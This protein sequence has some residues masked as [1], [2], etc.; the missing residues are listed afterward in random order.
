MQGQ[1]SFEFDATPVR[2][3]AWC[4]GSLAHRGRGALYCASR[5]KMALYRANEP[6]KHRDQNRRYVTANA[7]KVRLYKATYNKSH[8]R[9]S[10][11]DAHRAT[12]RILARAD[13]LARPDAFRAAS[14]KWRRANP[15]V[16]SAMSSR[17]RARKAGN[18][19]V[20]YKRQ[21]IFERD[22]WICQ[23]CMLTVDPNIR[24]PDPMSRSIDHIVPIVMGGPDSPDNVQLAHL[25]CNTSK[26]DR[27]T[28]WSVAI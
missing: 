17:R 25:R 12:A 2:T 24:N 6:E 21:D 18:G 26:G 23:L 1:Q 5:C 13:R 8:A 9:R 15:E 11:T 16:V 22:G 27:M 28:F 10:R 20:S 3:C 14:A 4:G 7:E 19:V